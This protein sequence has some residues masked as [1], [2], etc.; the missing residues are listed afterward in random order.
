MTTQHIGAADELLVQYRLLRLG[1][2]SVSLTNTRNRPEPLPLVRRSDARPLLLTVLLLA[3][4]IGALAFIPEW[5]CQRVE[6]FTNRSGVGLGCTPNTCQ[7]EVPTQVRIGST[8]TLADT[9]G[10]SSWTSTTA[11]LRGVAHDGGRCLT[12]RSCWLAA[13]SPVAP[14]R[15]QKR[16][17]HRARIVVD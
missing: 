17:N 12:K 16:R 9:M 4:F 2:I 15:F 7:V 1:S 8:L 3:A 11:N 5:A 13:V 14:H 6:T 10:P